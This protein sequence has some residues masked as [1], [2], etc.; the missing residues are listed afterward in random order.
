MFAL[1]FHT[2]QV[3][4]KSFALLCVYVYVYVCVTPCYQGDPSQSFL[5]ERKQ[6]EENAQI[7]GGKSDP[8]KT[9]GNVRIPSLWKPSNMRESN[10]LVTIWERTRWGKNRGG[11][12]L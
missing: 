11:R 2:S 6:R 8:K 9:S 4:E 5:F 12:N 10:D 1:L 3:P 7:H